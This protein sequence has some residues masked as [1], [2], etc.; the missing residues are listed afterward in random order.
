MRFRQPHLTRV[1]VHAVREHRAEGQR[2]EVDQTLQRPLVAPS[3]GIGDVFHVFGD[4]HMQ[5]GVLLA[6]QVA[7]FADRLV[8]HREPRVEPDGPDDAGRLVRLKEALA[9]VE[10]PAG[11]R[12][13]AVPLGGAV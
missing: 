4:V 1:Q 13:A 3:V 7:G 2:I 6:A 12:A 10:A 9:L 8:R 5:H 11:F